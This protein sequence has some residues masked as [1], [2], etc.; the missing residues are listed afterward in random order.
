MFSYITEE[1][2]WAIGRERAEEARIVRPHTREFPA[3]DQAS[4]PP[5]TG[6]DRPLWLG[7]QPSLNAR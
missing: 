2:I 4:T 3:S 6:G 1:L 5:P 7:L